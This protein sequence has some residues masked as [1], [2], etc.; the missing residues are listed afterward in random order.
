MNATLTVA[1]ALYVMSSLP[2]LAQ[3]TE[4][5]DGYMEKAGL[6]PLIARVEGNIQR[7][8]DGIVARPSPQTPKLN[9][10]QL[11][12]LR[13]AVKFAYDAD[14]LRESVRSNLTA[15]LPGGDTEAMMRW[16]DT[17]LAKRVTAV[18]SAVTTLEER[19]R[20]AQLAAKTYDESSAA[21]KSILDRMAKSSGA[22]D[23][24][25]MLAIEQQIGIARGVA[26]A[27][28]LDYRGPRSQS[29][30]FEQ[31]QKN[32]D[33]AVKAWVMNAAIVYAPMSDDEL[34]QYV[35]V[36]E[37]ASMRRVLDATSMAL[38]KA[39]SAAANELVRKV[40]SAAAAK[41]TT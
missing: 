3:P 2:V 18:E 25:A 1:A 37:R 30:K 41:P 16:F 14:R 27:V 26:A 4:M 21:R 13:G 22:A 39:L 35:A 23:M 8:I 7:G 6:V 10:E 20:A 33:A 15:L 5:I 29:E 9:A 12:R 31:R 36:L 24:A 34:S 40:D 38:E 17:P 19:Q 32:S 28:G 11:D